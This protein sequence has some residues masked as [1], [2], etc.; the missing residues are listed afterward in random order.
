MLIGFGETSGSFQ[1]PSW[2]PPR[3]QEEAKRLLEEAE[4]EAKAAVE[5][6]LGPCISDFDNKVLDQWGWEMGNGWAM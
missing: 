5:A 3:K 6:V 4:A 2:F 1:I